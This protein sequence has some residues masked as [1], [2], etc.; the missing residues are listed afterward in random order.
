MLRPIFAAALGVLLFIVSI[1][2]ATTQTPEAAQT[3]CNELTS[4]RTQAVVAMPPSN[5]D[6]RELVKTTTELPFAELV[7]VRPIHLDTT[8]S[9]LDDYAEALE[10]IEDVPA[11][12]SPVHDAYIVRV[13]L[14]SHLMRSFADGDLLNASG[15]IQH[16]E[17]NQ[18]T[19]S[20]ASEAA[21]QVCGMQWQ[22]FADPQ[23]AVYP[24]MWEG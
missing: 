15:Y 20:E 19:I 8:A 14:I 10:S 4:Y 5:D 3:S 16:L 12:V 11:V 2:P 17:A 7:G 13:V 21:E 24:F 1:V 6:L 23:P 22:W 18:Q 9:F